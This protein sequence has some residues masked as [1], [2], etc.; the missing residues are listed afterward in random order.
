M[1]W[2]K[3]YRRKRFLW[4]AQYTFQL[5]VKIL[6]FPHNSYHFFFFFITLMQIP[7][8]KSGKF[9]YE[10][11]DEHRHETVKKLEKN[12]IVFI[13]VLSPYNNENVKVLGLR[14]PC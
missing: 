13:N 12:K 5:S 1:E 11:P 9:I 6:K 14:S 3:N 4:G 2:K 8:T 7:I 10:L